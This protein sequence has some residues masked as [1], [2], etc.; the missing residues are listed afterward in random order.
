MAQPPVSGRGLLYVNSAIER[1]DVLDEE[2]FMDWYDNDHIAEVL[3]TSGVSSAWRFKDVEFG[4]VEKPYLAMYPLE[5]IGFTQTDEFKKIRV[6]SDKI[7][8]GAAIYDVANF[9]VRVYNLIQVFDPTKKG[10]GHTKTIISAQIEPGP[11]VSDEEFDRWYREEHLEELCKGKGFL[12]TTRYK[13]A[14]ARSN[15]QSRVLKGLATSSEPPPQPPTWLAIHEFDTEDVSV[16][17]L[18]DIADSP[19]TRKVLSGCKAIEAPIFKIVKA[20][21]EADFFHGVEV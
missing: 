15:A 5:D 16:E 9:D 1:T 8:G 10:K 4:K 7:P 18:M 17:N 3:E 21:G 6:H 14:Y 11:E 19:W 13:L 2:K 12:R 20:F